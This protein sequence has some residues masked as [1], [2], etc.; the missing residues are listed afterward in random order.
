MDNVYTGPNKGAYKLSV[1]S[2]TPTKINGVSDRIFSTVIDNSNNLYFAKINGLYILQISLSWTKEQSQFN[3]IDSTK[4]K[5]WTRNDWLTVDG[6]L[7]IEIQNNNIDKVLFDNFLQPQTAKQWNINVKPETSEKDHILQVIFT[8]DGKQYTSK[9]IVSMQTKI[10]PPIPPKPENLSDV[11]KFG[12]DNNLG[13]ILDNNDGTI[14]TKIQQI[15]SRIIDFS[16]IKIEKK[17]M[18]SATLTAKKDSK[19]YQGSVV[20]KYNVVPTTVV[21]LMIDLK[22]KSPSTQTDI[23]Y[24]GQIDKTIITNPVNSFYYAN[25]ESKITMIK[26]TESSVITGFVYGADNQWN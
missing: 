1:D 19:S 14:E 10:D 17:D 5:T 2:D 20:V 7:N 24:A 15:N 22:P 12:S 13:N 6:E 16:Q 11:I 18:H 21:D 4:K 9:I 23:D 3:L 25:S 8:L 26:P